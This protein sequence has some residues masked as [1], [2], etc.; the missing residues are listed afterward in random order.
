[1]Y[2][3]SVTVLG[4]TPFFILLVAAGRPRYVGMPSATL[5]VRNVRSPDDAERRGVRL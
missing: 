2:N 3:T 1:M 5:C 4:A